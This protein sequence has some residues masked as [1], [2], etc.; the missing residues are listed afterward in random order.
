[1]WIFCH[2]IRYIKIS[3]LF[4][5]HQMPPLPKKYSSDLQQIIRNMLHQEPDRRPTVSRI[6]RD[7]YIK[8]NIAIFLEETKKGYISL[9]MK[10]Y[11]F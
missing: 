7:P 1:M 4:F 2:D 9:R 6:L 8:R 10:E 11:S 3:M 5:V